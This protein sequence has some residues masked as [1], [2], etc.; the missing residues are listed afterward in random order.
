MLFA[1]WWA[2]LLLTFGS[3]LEVLGDKKKKPPARGSQ[4]DK[5]N[6]TKP[7]NPPADLLLLEAALEKGQTIMRDQFAAKAK[8]MRGRF[9]VGPRVK[10]HITVTTPVKKFAGVALHL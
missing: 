3:S 6:Q 7:K 8:M 10:N 9:I 5:R 4:Q 2:L 1:M